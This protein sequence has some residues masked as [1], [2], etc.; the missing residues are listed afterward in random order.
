MRSNADARAMRRRQNDSNESMTFALG[1]FSGDS[2]K[3]HGAR[4]N[5]TRS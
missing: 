3:I 2:Q 5:K 4:A 1:V